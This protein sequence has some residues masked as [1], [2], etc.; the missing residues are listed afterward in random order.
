V[1]KETH[2]QELLAWNDTYNPAL[3]EKWEIEAEGFAAFFPNRNILSEEWK[4]IVWTSDSVSQ[5]QVDRAWA[6]IP[7]IVDMDTLYKSHVHLQITS[8][9][10]TEEGVK[11]LRIVNEIIQ[12]LTLVGDCG[13]RVVGCEIVARRADNNDPFHQDK[14][15]GRGVF[16][17]DIKDTE[18]NSPRGVR[19]LIDFGS[20]TR[21]KMYVL[22][23][24]IQGGISSYG[25]QG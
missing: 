22:P 25:L 5:D 17:R 12:E 4:A 20:W 3:L 13:Y 16:E 11:F 15:T 7:Y 10:V 1:L 8:I 18:A 2:K 19:V 9:I 24:F 23:L 6:L 14:R 21:E